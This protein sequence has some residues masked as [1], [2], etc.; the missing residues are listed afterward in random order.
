MEPV[1]NLLVIGYRIGRSKLIVAG[2]LRACSTSAVACC[3]LPAGTAWLVTMAID[4]CRRAYPL[5]TFECW[6]SGI[7]WEL[8]PSSALFTC[9]SAVQEC[10]STV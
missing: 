1:N 8:I 6:F 2:P 7:V 3:P 10:N 5:V 9:I 4:S